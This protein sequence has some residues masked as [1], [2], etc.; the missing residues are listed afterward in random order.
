MAGAVGAGFGFNPNTL[1][2]Q[3]KL[4]YQRQQE[5]DSAMHGLQMAGTQAQIAN[6]NR[7]TGLAN[8]AAWS[9]TGANPTDQAD[10]QARNMRAQQGMSNYGMSQQEF[11]H[12]LGAGQLARFGSQTR[13]QEAG[14][15]AAAEKRRMEMFAPYLNNFG[16]MTQGGGPVPQHVDYA[17]LTGAEDAARSASFARAKDQAGLI[18]RS[19]M[20]SLAG[21]MG[22]RGLTGSGLAA[23]AAGGVINQ[24]ANQLGEVNREEAIQGGNLARQRASEQYQGGIT[25]RGQDISAINAQR[26]AMLGL[27]G[28]FTGQVTARY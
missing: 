7:N 23:N 6:V 20:N 15:Q 2:P 17:G 24:Q 28:G 3:Q 26:Q 13:E 16:N 4:D 11:E 1:N 19:A 21:V 10:E 25:E 14:L 18:G 27:M 12:E 5:S 8:Q 9:S 22:A